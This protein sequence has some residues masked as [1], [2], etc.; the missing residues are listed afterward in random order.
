[1]PGFADF[2]RTAERQGL[3][4]ALGGRTP[5]ERGVDEFNAQLKPIRDALDA[6]TTRPELEAA[7]KQLAEAWHR[8]GGPMDERFD[9]FAERLT[10]PALNRVQ[11]GELESIQRDYGGAPA[12]PRPPDTEGPLTEQGAFIPARPERPKDLE[13]STRMYQATGA[14]PQNFQEI[15]GTPALIQQ[16]EGQAAVE[17]EKVSEARRKARTLEELPD[18]PQPGGMISPRQMGIIHPAGLPQYEPQRE[19]PA[20]PLQALRER[21]LEAQTERLLRPPPEPRRRLI[22]R[23]LGDRVETFDPETGDIIHTAPKGAVSTET[24]GPVKG[25]E[26][27]ELERSIARLAADRGITDPAGIKQLFRSQGYEVEGEPILNVP[28]TTPTLTGK[29]LGAIGLPGP[30]E[31]DKE[32]RPIVA[33]PTLKGDFNIITKPKTVTRGPSGAAPTGQAPAAAPPTVLMRA[34]DGSQRPVPADRVE[35]FKRRGATIVGR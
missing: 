34:P 33:P 11:R 27:V 31:K 29:A 5:Q 3:G 25:V 22:T 24:T 21:H 2:L 6:A 4:A 14:K 7:A 13:F 1:M 19:R 35:E 10:V 16:R 23:D 12:Q 15:F 20:D 30:V 28:S 32:G 18:T 26:R 9:K 8:T 17:Q